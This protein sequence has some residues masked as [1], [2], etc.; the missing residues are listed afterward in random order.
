MQSEEVNLVYGFR[1][2][3][4]WLHQWITTH[5]VESGL[6][7]EMCT[8]EE[9]PDYYVNLVTRVVN[10]LLAVEY[11]EEFVY[12]GVYQVY[13]SPLMPI[14]DDGD[15]YDD[16]DNLYYDSDVRYHDQSLYEYFLEPFSASEHLDAKTVSIREVV[17][18]SAIHVDA[19]IDLWRRV[20]MDFNC[21]PPPMRI[22]AV[23]SICNF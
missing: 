23:G 3:Q 22:H 21:D 17:E 20:C 10:R 5:T 8:S 18:F 7:Y 19:K 9:S 14:D 2:D 12:I 13:S 15:D 16:D 11:G 6:L 4:R 1:I